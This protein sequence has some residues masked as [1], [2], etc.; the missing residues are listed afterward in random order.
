M[1]LCGLSVDDAHWTEDKEGDIIVQ[2]QLLH[3]LVL[4]YKDAHVQPNVMILNTDTCG[5]WSQQQEYHEISAMYW[6]WI[7]IF[8]SVTLIIA[9]YCKRVSVENFTLNF[10]GC[11]Q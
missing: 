8:V 6:N 2:L 4:L 7:I 11:P 9:F 10:I 3:L 5:K 1:R